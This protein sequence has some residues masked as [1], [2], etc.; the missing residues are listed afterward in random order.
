MIQNTKCLFSQTCI[1]P[2]IG[3]LG[4]WMEEG[5]VD[6]TITRVNMLGAPG[7]GKTCAECLLLNEDPP[8]DNVSTPIARPTVRATRVAVEDQ[9]KWKRVTTD[10]LLEE[11]AAD[12]SASANKIQKMEI[13]PAA[14]N[15]SPTKSTD[16]ALSFVVSD[17]DTSHM[18]PPVENKTK[19][20]T[21]ASKTDDSKQE[22]EKE[23]SVPEVASIGIDHSPSLA[24]PVPVTPHVPPPPDQP[25]S[26]TIIKE[27]QALPPNYRSE[28]VIQ[29]ILSAHPKGIRLSDH[30]LYVID[31]GG[32][33]AYQELLPLFTRAASLNI[34][35]LDLSKSFEEKF[36]LEYRIGGKYFPCH[37]KS[38]QLAIFQSAVSTGATFKPLDISHVTKRPTHTM[39]L[40]L[41]TH[42]DKDL[43]DYR[44]HKREA[45]LQ[46]AISTLQP[47]LRDCVIRK[48]NGSIIFP[49]NTMA[50]SRKRAKY[51]E[52]ICQAIRSHGSAASL[53]IK[54]PIQWFA[55]ELSL[56]ANKS[57][58]PIEEA[59]SIGERYGMS[60]V[61]TKQALKYFHDVGLKL[62]YP[63]V[64]GVVFNDPRPILEILSQL[65][66]LTY[67]NNDKCRDLILIKQLPQNVTNNLKE[68]F[69]NEDIFDHLKS[70]ADV[71]MQPQFQLSDLVKLLLHLHIITEVVDNDK[72]RYFIPYALPSYNV[73]TPKMKDT[74][75]KPLLIVWR[76]EESEQIL[77]VPQG[78]FPLTIVHLLNQ[79][80]HVTKIPPSTKDCY[81]YRDAMS[82]K[83]TFI[84]DYIL[85]IINRYTHI[86]VYFTGP[87]EHCPQVRQLVI[88]AI[89]RSTE[90]M[91]MK[92]NH[93]TAFSCPKK[94]NCYCIVNEVHRVVNCTM[95]TE[96]AD[97][98]PDIDHYWCWFKSGKPLLICLYILI[99]VMIMLMAQLHE[100]II[101][102][103]HYYR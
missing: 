8:S 76:K 42:Y 85:H 90:K 19:L 6:L 73:V 81:K 70:K 24:V 35:T 16:H 4:Q 57:I 83:I 50:K 41:G 103:S 21:S 80:R 46:S 92:H 9:A 89:D 102:Y 20:L 61:N 38:T 95:C 14:P 28:E 55:F 47:Y 93:V 69:F 77:P 2:I 43:F 26:D 18:P 10:D 13:E 52:E 31:S 75:A 23:P 32:Q 12:L 17:P 29:Q 101:I 25:S 34:I 1:F 30:W 98:R 22:I 78:I 94:K 72:G 91:H 99:I 45:S 100:C 66:A 86:E 62:Y 82:L 96:S 11:L 67:V 64:T 7:A 37:S 58:I 87:P 27:D 65:L 56:P 88:E 51:N 53:E 3:A 71:F 54:I 33:P 79:K 49:V 59:L 5:S 15:V 68:G 63:E 44:L 39:H 74:D 36:K 48:P 84:R 40:V 97:I 60:E